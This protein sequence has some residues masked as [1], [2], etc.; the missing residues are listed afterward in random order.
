MND[1]NKTL[2]LAHVIC[3]LYFIQIQ[4][5]ET[6]VSLETEMIMCPSTNHTDEHKT[7]N[8][9]CLMYNELYSKVKAASSSEYKT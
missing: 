8:L 5:H 1:W 9:Y 4:K 6:K 3:A 7:F 2:E